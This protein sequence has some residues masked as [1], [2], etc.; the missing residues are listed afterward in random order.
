LKDTR[1]LRLFCTASDALLLLLRRPSSGDDRQSMHDTVA[2]YL[3]LVMLMVIMSIVVRCSLV[4]PPGWSG[5]DA[6]VL[7]RARAEPQPNWSRWLK[8]VIFVLCVSK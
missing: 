8:D 6:V 4:F 3:F 1:W 5:R 2:R 7:L